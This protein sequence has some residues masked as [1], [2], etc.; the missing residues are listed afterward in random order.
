MPWTRAVLAETA[1]PRTYKKTIMS[2]TMKYP[3][4]N[5][6]VWWY[7]L[8]MKQFPRL[9]ATL[10]FTHNLPHTRDSTV[11][12]DDLVEGDEN[13]SVW[14]T[15]QNKRKQEWESIFREIRPKHLHHISKV[16]LPLSPLQET[17]GLSR[18]TL[19]SHYLV[20]ENVAWRPDWGLRRRTLLSTVNRYVFQNGYLPLEAITLWYYL[21]RKQVNI[22]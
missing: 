4:L 21:K 20:R 11:T 12:H 14:F 15:E 22:K 5:T 3:R 1:W 16:F 2:S 10:L 18:I 6:C 19:P 8:H 17:F 13:S 7:V 9:W